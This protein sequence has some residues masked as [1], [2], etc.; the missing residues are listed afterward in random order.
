MEKLM[1]DRK[2]T[3]CKVL[4]LPSGLKVEV[5][6]GNTVLQAARK[7][8]VY[9]TS[10]CGGDGYCGKCRLVL[11][12]GEIEA[13]PTT[14]LSREEI[15]ENYFLACQAKVKSDLTV[16]V[17]KEHELDKSPILIDKD[18][19]RFSTM[20][21]SVAAE[22]IYKH[23]PLV[24][25]VYLKL[26]PPTVQKNIA[27]HERVL[28]AIR[29]QLAVREMQTG[30]RILEQL[31]HILRQSDW[32]ITAT[33]AKRWGTYE[34]VQ[35]ESGD[36]SSENFGIALDIGT[37]TVVAHLVDLV[38]A[39]TVDAEATYNSQMK[40]G[41]DYIRRIIYAEQ[42]NAFD[43]MQSCIIRDVNDLIAILVERNGVRLNDITCAVAAGNT[44]MLHFLLKLN[45]TNIRRTPYIPTANFIP[46]L[47]A[48][49]AGI[50]ISGRGL[51]YC[52]P[53]VA[54]YIGSD[55]TAGI[56]ATGLHKNRKLSL[57]IDIGTNGEIV[58][59]NRE[60]MVAASSS[61]GPAFEGSGIKHG[62]RAAAGAI[63]KIDIMPDLSVR[64]KTIGG[65]SP[66]GICGSGLLDLL[67]EL[68][69]MGGIDRTG[70]LQS[71]RKKDRFEEAEDGLQF[72]LVDADDENGSRKIVF[73]QPDVTNLIRSKAGVYAAISI[74]LKTM[75]VNQMDI[76]C[77]YLAGGFGN[78]LDVSNAVAIGMLPD[79]PV[80]R[81]HFVG[82]S[83][84][85]GSKLPLL[86]MDAY[87]A[88]AEIANKMTYI[89][90]M[91]N[92]EYMEEFIK[93]NFI[94]NT[95]LDRFPTVMKM[96]EAG[97]GEKRKRGA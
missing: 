5:P 84:I 71:D 73:T 3:P 75:N 79:V 24:R 47:R 87:E 36:T 39:T 49:E 11:D 80:E 38:N 70:T 40:Y 35:V 93:A 69:C 96:F 77:V 60:W 62:M 37:T 64:Y 26:T 90:L 42:N 30:Y 53:S 86:S 2:E 61:A 50:K 65:G 27:D 29:K 7:A 44:A 92:P 31:P 83:S 4:F 68:Y 20:S 78:Y 59:G 33:V 10:I 41:E 67:A 63:E 21:T 28:T 17:P 19:H 16:T 14:L 51:L 91:T 88:A 76:E 15:R 18:A 34:L 56:L 9:V 57:F 52:L 32:K 23:Q 48:A 82:N 1:P 72:V 66:K 12:K 89:D 25:K 22:V 58:L 85:A 81:I 55:I 54:A 43:E 13:K 94:P 74:L 45:P 6:Y 97:C 46:P 8:G 95:E